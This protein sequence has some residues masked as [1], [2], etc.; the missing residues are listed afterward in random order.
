MMERFTMAS[1]IGLGPNCYLKT[2]R[3]LSHAT[4]IHIHYADYRD[5][6]VVHS[7]NGTVVPGGNFLEPRSENFA[8]AQINHYYRK[9][10]DEFSVKC[11]RGYCDHHT[12]DPDTF[13]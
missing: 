2:F 13:H 9:S 8:V 4:E 12:L 7:A 10:K 6:S 11:L 1:E 5:G 3:R